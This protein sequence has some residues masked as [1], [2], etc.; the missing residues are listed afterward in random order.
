MQNLD[1]L[2]VTGAS[3]M[4]GKYVDF[5][6]RPSR[7]ELDITDKN[8][9]FDFIHKMKPSAVLH[10]A[11]KTDMRSCEED[12]KEAMRVN[13]LGAE[14]VGKAAQ[15]VGARFILLSTNAVFDGEQPSPYSETD[16]P[17]PLNEYGRSKLAGE[18][19]VQLLSP[20][21]LIVRT[22]WVF[23]GGK[24]FD[25]RFVGRI[26]AQLREPSMTVVSD[27]RGTPT[28]AKDLVH[29]I[30]GLILSEKTG[31]VHVANSGTASRFEQASLIAD[32]CRYQGRLI[33][34]SLHD[35]KSVPPVLKNEA[36]VSA[37]L[38][39]RSWQEALTDYLHTEWNFI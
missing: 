21:S 33:P 35:I 32:V 27:T 22:G 29:T 34:V 20:T 5:G 6:I 3:G 31:I 18:H 12:H 15:S 14:L 38:F 1:S 23:G 16:L 36:L 26:M 24:E 19:F 2:L 17:H 4:I 13:A 11:A 8:K 25:K 10:L 9:V 37:T 30:K 7:A 39:L 28:Y